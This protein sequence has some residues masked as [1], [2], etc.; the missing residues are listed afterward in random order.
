MHKGHSRLKRGK[1]EPET[2]GSA[3]HSNFS[4]NYN[5]PQTSTNCKY[6]CATNYKLGIPEPKYLC[7]TIFLPT[8]RRL[9]PGGCV[10]K[11]K[12]G[13]KTSQ[14]MGIGPICV[15]ILSI[16][17]VLFGLSP[18]IHPSR[19][20]S[21]LHRYALGACCLYHRS[22]RSPL[23]RQFVANISSILLSCQSIPTPLGGMKS[24]GLL[25]K[26]C[27]ENS[28]ALVEISITSWGQAK[29]K[30]SCRP[31]WVGRR[32]VLVWRPRVSN[33]TAPDVRVGRRHLS[34]RTAE[35]VESG[36]VRHRCKHLQKPR[37]AGALCRT[38]AWRMWVPKSF[39]TTLW[40]KL[41]K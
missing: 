29:G 26:N 14:V 20:V 33:R 39:S 11:G 21:V 25:L 23:L 15:P 8:R 41:A 24:L 3:F 30:V 34:S 36:D 40:A 18:N 1:I 35:G 16:F 5:I 19:N 10:R 4:C 27:F 12:R 22:L 13:R 7:A 9:K 2:L 37:A 32:D 38:A 6:L 31:R 28:P 17:L